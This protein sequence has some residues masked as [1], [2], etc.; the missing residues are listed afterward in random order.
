MKKEETLYDY[1]D[2]RAKDMVSQGYV[3]SGHGNYGGNKQYLISFDTSYPDARETQTIKISRHHYCS[4]CS[5]LALPIQSEIYTKNNYKVTGYTCVCKGAMDEIQMQKDIKEVNNKLQ[6]FKN[7]CESEIRNLKMTHGLNNP[8]TA[9]DLVKRIIENKI[10][11][12]TT[13]QELT[14]FAAELI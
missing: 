9:E 8:N 5:R 2:D 4:Y 6:K 7:E 1:A 12:I 10:S 3:G 14:E 13:I 11:R